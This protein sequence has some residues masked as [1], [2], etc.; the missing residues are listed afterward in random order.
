MQMSTFEILDGIFPRD[1]LACFL[2]WVS[3]E[4]DEEEG[5]DDFRSLEEEGEINEE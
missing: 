1:W 4:F 2:E 3:G 5:P